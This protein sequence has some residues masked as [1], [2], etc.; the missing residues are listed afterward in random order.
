[1]EDV[2]NSHVNRNRFYV[3]AGPRRTWA[4]RDDP[5]RVRAHRLTT[6]R[7]PQIV[8]NRFVSHNEQSYVEVGRALR[9][10]KR[11]WSDFSKL[12]G[13]KSFDK[14]CMN[15]WGWEDRTAVYRNIEAVEVY[16][17][18]ASMQ[19]DVASVQPNLPSFT[20]A[21]AMK[22]L[23]ASEQRELASKNKDCPRREQ[24]LSGQ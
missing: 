23:E 22:N 10:I 15:K 17:N 18:V 24:S 9:E 6:P 1:M 5:R 2:F 16:E 19:Q 20:Q 21:L 11:G 13:V 3:V 14:Y 12:A 7:V 8:W 4:P